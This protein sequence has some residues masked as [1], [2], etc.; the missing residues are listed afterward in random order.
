MISI[1]KITK[2][3]KFSKWSLIDLPTISELNG[4]CDRFEFFTLNSELEFHGLHMS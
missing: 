4:N 1:E 3:F 2:Y